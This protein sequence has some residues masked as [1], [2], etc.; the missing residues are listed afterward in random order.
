MLVHGKAAIR[1][2]IAIVES[3]LIRPTSAEAEQLLGNRR[4]V[5]GERCRT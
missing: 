2:V 1:S 5:E 3:G 4:L